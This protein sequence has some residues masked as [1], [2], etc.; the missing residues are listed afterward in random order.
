MREG[1]SAYRIGGKSAAQAAA[2][3]KGDWKIKLETMNRARP[4]AI[5][6]PRSVA[7]RKHERT[8]APRRGG[9]FNRYNNP[10]RRPPK[11]RPAAT[12]H[13]AAQSATATNGSNRF[14]L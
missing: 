7:G 1:A 13:V 12:A 5:G 3:L 2:V 9:G 8:R 14:C 4:Y 10:R 11:T 6:G